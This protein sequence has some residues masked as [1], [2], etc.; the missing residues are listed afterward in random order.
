MVHQWV[1]YLIT[2]SSNVRFEEEQGEM[3]S[4]LTFCCE[5]I[6]TKKQFS[7]MKD[8]AYQFDYLES[9]APS[10]LSRMNQVAQ[11]EAKFG[12]TV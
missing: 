9:I 3:G 6:I 2:H 4:N 10:C 8:A 5:K 1:Q 7:F 11:A 12:C